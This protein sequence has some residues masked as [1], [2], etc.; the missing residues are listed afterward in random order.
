MPDLTMTWN[1]GEVSEI[2]AGEFGAD[3]V[4]SPGMIALQEAVV[5]VPF[6]VMALHEGASLSVEIQY[7]LFPSLGFMKAV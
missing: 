4:Q 2:F 5:S 1:F 7:N 6:V 3:C